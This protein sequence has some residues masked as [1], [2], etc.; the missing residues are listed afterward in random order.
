MVAPVK[1]TDWLGLLMSTKLYYDVGE[2]VSNIAALEGL[3]TKLKEFSASVVQPARVG[4]VP[5]KKLVDL[6]VDETAIWLAKSGLGDYCDVFK[7]KRMCGRSLR[8][9]FRAYS[10]PNPVLPRP[11]LALLEED[12]KMVTGDAFLLLDLLSIS[13]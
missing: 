12:M 10:S 11:V 3:V 4:T 13:F 2:E 6:D 8:A 5:V 9:L 7:Q 1:M